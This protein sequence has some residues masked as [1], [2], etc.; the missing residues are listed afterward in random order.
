MSDSIKPRDNKWNEEGK[1]IQDINLCMCNV[2]VFC[3]AYRFQL[4]GYRDDM[5]YL[6]IYK[7]IMD[8]KSYIE[9]QYTLL[10]I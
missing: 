10:A 4:A 1:Y 3:P 8:T 6:D 2:V 9:N 5:E 7:R